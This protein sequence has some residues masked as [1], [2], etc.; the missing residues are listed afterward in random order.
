MAS[1]PPQVSNRPHWTWW[2]AVAVATALLFYA[3]QRLDL[4]AQYDLTVVFLLSI[5]ALSMGFLWGFVGI[6]SLGQTAFYGLG[7]Y[8]F[9]LW[10]LNTGDT[11]LALVLAIVLPAL[12]SAALG[13]FMFYGRISDIYLSVITLVVTLILEKAIRATS[14]DA[15]VIGTVRLNG[16]NGIP[17]IPDL[18]VPWDPS[19]TLF[20]DGKYYVAAVFLVL[21]Y[22]GLRL[23]LVTRFG[24]VLVGIRENERRVE[25]LGYDVRRSPPRAERPVTCAALC[26]TPG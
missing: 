10:S 17:G 23:V 11:T 6:L 9:A 20:I 26:G 14:G 5:L 22:V 18:Q 8:A 19:T 2:V 1:A 13:Y 7:G 16:Q 3:P 21:V 25:L 4:A 24:R 15:F 12:F